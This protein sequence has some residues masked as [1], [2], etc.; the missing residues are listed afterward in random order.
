LHPAL[1]LLEHALVL[2]RRAVDDDA[3]LERKHPDAA[4]LCSSLSATDVQ[5]RRYRRALRRQR[6]P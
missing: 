2:A 4:D 5:L 3:L 1:A 6:E